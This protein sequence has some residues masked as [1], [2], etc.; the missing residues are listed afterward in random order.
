MIISESDFKMCKFLS[1][2]TF[3]TFIFSVVMSIFD[4][5]ILLCLGIECM[6]VNCLL[7]FG[8]IGV[9]NV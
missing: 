5:K 2:I 3:M 1:I 9:K 4:K 7:L 6:I 8:F